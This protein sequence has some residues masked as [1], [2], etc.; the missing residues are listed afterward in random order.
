MTSLEFAEAVRCLSGAA[1]RAGY[2]APS[3]RSRPRGSNRRTIRRRSDGSATVAVALRQRP[4]P[5][6]LGDLI[7][8]IIATN[9]L[10][11]E[12]AGLLRDQLWSAVLPVLEHSNEPASLPSNVVP[13]AA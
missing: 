1:R 11:G 7:D 10:T 13:F 4:M 9:D 2:R 3:F 5:A 6:V 12:P 8:G